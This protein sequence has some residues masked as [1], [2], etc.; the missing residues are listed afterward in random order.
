MPAR[1][2]PIYL[3]DHLAGSTAGVELARRTFAENRNTDLGEF[4]SG[5]LSEIEEDRA[6]LINL[7]QALSIKPSAIKVAAAWTVEKAGRLKLNGQVR[8]YSP[9]SRVVEL[10]GLSSGIAGKRA[11]WQALGEI[12][13]R[14]HRLREFDFDALAERASSQLERLKPY[15]LA[16]NR[17]A[18]G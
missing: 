6:T 2:L 4:L 16:A 17:E 5:L 15:R 10:E 8:G 3:N 9:L 1:Y 12:R 13:V 18:F 7:M 11:L 14:D